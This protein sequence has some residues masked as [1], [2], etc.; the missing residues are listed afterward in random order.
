M[1]LI[2]ASSDYCL[3]TTKPLT[4]KMLFKFQPANQRPLTGSFL[5][6]CCGKNHYEICT[7]VA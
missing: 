2:A 1:V 6:G 4:I 5:K 3:N 7:N